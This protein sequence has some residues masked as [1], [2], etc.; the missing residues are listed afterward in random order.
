[1]EAI[2]GED[3]SSSKDCLTGGCSTSTFDVSS[4]ISF[5]SRL[6]EGGSANSIVGK[7]AKEEPSSSIIMLFPS[8]TS[9]ITAETISCL[10]Q[11]SCAFSTSLGLITKTI[12]S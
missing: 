5:N 4:G 11:I 7:S 3:K 10:S 1:M 6:S 9:P 2:L 8:I 12:L